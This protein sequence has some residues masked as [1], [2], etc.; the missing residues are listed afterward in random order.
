[1]RV[2]VGNPGPEP[3][4]GAQVTVSSSSPGLSFPQGT[5][6]A[7]P[8]IAA[9]GAAE[10]SIEAALAATEGMAEVLITVDSSAAAS[11]EVAAG[12]ALSTPVNLDEMTDVSRLDDVE[13][14]STPWATTGQG[15]ADIWS[16]P[17]DEGGSNHLWHGSDPGSPSD[18]QLV[19]PAVTALATGSLV[20]SFQHRYDFEFSDGYYW[21]GGVIEL[22][23]DAGASWHDLSE[24]VEI[25][26]DGVLTDVSGNPL[27]NRPAFAWQSADYPTMQPVSFDFGSAFAGQT[28]QFRFRIGADASVGATGWDIDNI[29]LAGIEETPFPR[30]EPEDGCAATPPDAGPDEPGEPDAGG[31]DA[32]G[33]DGAA[34]DDDGGCGCRAASSSPS[35]TLALLLLALVA[36]RRRRV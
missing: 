12:A 13:A 6:V 22:T 5:S 19:S 30:L 36:V 9:F 25:Q 27:M 29:E 16:R 28:V 35:S 8:T 14:V 21:D 4:A 18:T 3:L 26:Y 11:C 23:T 20:L 24:F 32:G 17:I 33:G 15:A 1:V 10:V 2:V 7:V 31:G 34:E